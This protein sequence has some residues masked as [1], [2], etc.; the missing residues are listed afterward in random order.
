MPNNAYALEYMQGI[1]IDM[2]SAFTELS[3]VITVAVGVSFIMRVIKQPLIIGYIITGLLVGPALLNIVKS[4]ETLEVF[5]DFGIALLLFIVGLGLNPR[6]IKE[7]G[8]IAG[9]IAF[10]KV[11]VATAIGF[12]VAKLLGFSDTAAIY[13]GMAL[14]F[15]STIIILKLL[16]DK[17]EQ[18]RLYGK[19]S[20]GYLLIEDLIATIIMVV[21]SASGSGD[22]SAND[23]LPLFYKIILL[24]A[25]LTTVRLFFLSKVQKLI[26]SS[27]E[28]L[29]LFAI[30][31]GIGIASLFKASGFSLE[32]GALIAGVTLAPLPFAQEAASRLKPLRDFFIV[33]FF[34]LLGSHLELN[35]A[36][37]VLPVALLFSVIVLIINPLVVM[38][39]MGIGGYTKKTSFSAGLTGAQISEFSLILIFLANRM[40]QVDEEV[41][42]LV[43]IIT[44]LTIAIST[45]TITYSDKLYNFFGDSLRMFER[46]KIRPQRESRHSY[47]LVLFGY[48]KG[49]HEFLKVFQQLNKPYIV[50][51]YDPRV[52]DT[53]EA[54]NANYL[55]G[56]VT[57]FELLD[58]LDIEKARL[59]VSTVTDI[60]VNKSIATWIEKANPHTVF[61]CSAD[62]IEQAA[63]LY[64]EGVSYVMLP[65]Y[66]GSE[67]IGAFIKKSGLK[68]SEF[69]KFREKHLEYLESH[70]EEVEKSQSDTAT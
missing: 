30:G 5:A 59:M 48:L 49:G 61:I 53:L 19:I 21:V 42:A 34:V 9:F 20:I 70:L 32:I 1:K 57:D 13:I 58:E 11:V 2:H 23:I 65:H 37:N 31:W 12:G 36:I 27:Q 14:S 24:I 16:S 62:T 66:I 69:K 8:K 33:L 43:T 38:T 4:P 45:Y 22:F 63:E 17:K 40:G 46:R 60:E 28:F 64:S 35:H 68:K 39:I 55:Y 50:V 25:A 6:V 10:F 15:S 67:K 3:L 56:D 18:S 7:V 51:D 47:E 41:V 54:I 26:S 44:L 29:F 52:I